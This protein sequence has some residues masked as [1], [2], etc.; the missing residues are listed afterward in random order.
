MNSR[1]TPVSQVSCGKLCFLRIDH[2][3]ASIKSSNEITLALVNFISIDPKVSVRPPIHHP[4][5]RPSSP[6][7]KSHSPLL[8]LPS[9][10]DVVLTPRPSTVSGLSKPRFFLFVV[11]DLSSILSILAR[12]GRG[13]ESI[14]FRSWSV[15]V[16]DLSSRLVLLRLIILLVFILRGVI[17]DLYNYLSSFGFLTH[18]GRLER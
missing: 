9:F 14:V 8:V 17:Q 1:N 7:M 2:L 4:K 15:T 11:M 10:P 13:K 16:R 6:S 18:E 5:V 3:N 12:L